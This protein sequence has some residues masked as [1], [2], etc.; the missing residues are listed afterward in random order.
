M[1]KSIWV[2]C[3]KCV[4]VQCKYI[5]A[6]AVEVSDLLGSWY[7]MGKVLWCVAAPLD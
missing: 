5:G 7:T 1:C 3:A 2:M 4:D 6:V